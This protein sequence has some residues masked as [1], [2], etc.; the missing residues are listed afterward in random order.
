MFYGAAMLMEA[1]KAK[2]FENLVK[3]V[4]EIFLVAACDDEDLGGVDI[5][6]LIC[7]N[8][9]NYS[10]RLVKQAIV[11]SNILSIAGYRTAK[12][13]TE[14]ATDLLNTEIEI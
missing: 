13:I 10:S 12:R 8:L 7:Y 1:I 5:D 9:P 2:R 14:L 11:A 6:Y 4:E 3:Q